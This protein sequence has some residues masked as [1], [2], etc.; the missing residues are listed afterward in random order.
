MA[1]A[2]VPVGLRRDHASVPDRCNSS[3]SPTWVVS[4]LALWRRLGVVYPNKGTCISGILLGRAPCRAAA[5]RGRSA[6]ID[7]PKAAPFLPW[8]AYL[9]LVGIYVKDMSIGA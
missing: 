6:R 1:S 3:Q 8:T 4:L 2:P 7:S 5:I 9:C